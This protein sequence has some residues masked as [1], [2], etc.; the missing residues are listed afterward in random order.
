MKLEPGPGLLGEISRT[1][2]TVSQMTNPPTPWW[3]GISD[4]ESLEIV[5]VA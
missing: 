5:E 4:Y 1:V 3:E 2:R